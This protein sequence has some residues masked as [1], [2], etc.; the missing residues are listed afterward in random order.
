MRLLILTA[1]VA[2]FALVA[3]AQ[4]P[5]SSLTPQRPPPAAPPKPEV[6]PALTPQVPVAEIIPD[7]PS[8]SELKPPGPEATPRINEILRN[9]GN[10]LIFVE[11]GEGSG[12][13]FLCKMGGKTALITNQ[14]VI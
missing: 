6:K 2:M 3:H 12:S 9:A 4:L 10:T 8:A 13:G 1:F 11:G 14:H 7:Q 5:P